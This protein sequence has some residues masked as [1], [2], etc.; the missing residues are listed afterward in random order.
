MIV[1]GEP[2]AKLRSEA[3]EL[4]NL[5]ASLGERAEI[6]VPKKILDNLRNFVKLCFE[7]PVDPA[8]Q[9]A[10]INRYILEFKEDIPGYLDVALMLYPHEDSKAFQY[11][12]KR[13]EFKKR[14]TSFIDTESLDEQSKKYA[15]NILD[16]PDFSIGTP[17]V[18]KSHIDFMSEIQIGDSIRNLRKF[19]DV[20][21]IVEHIE[22]GHWNFLMDT[23]EQMIV[24]SSHYTTKPEKDDFLHRT[25]WAVNFKGLNGL[26]RTVV[27]G[28]AETAYNLIAGEVFNKNCVKKIEHPVTE[29]H[30]NDLYNKM[31]EDNTS[32][33]VVKVDNARKNYFSGTKKWFP[34]LTRLVIV[35]DSPES[36]RTNTSLVFSFH[37]G[38]INTLNK[39]HTKKL[40]APANTQLNIRLILESV[41]R[42]KIVRFRDEINKK[43]KKFD[44][45]LKE[46]KVKQ[47]GEEDNFGF[48]LGLYK[49]DGFTRQ[50]LKDKYSLEK[51][52]DF[53]FFLENLYDDDTRERQNIELIKEFEAGI[54]KYF[55]SGIEQV[56]TA[57]IVEGGGRNQI[58]TYGEYALEKNLR[59]IVTEAKQKCALILDIL[60]NNY[61]RTLNNH[62][63][64]NFGINLFLEKYQEYIKKSVNEA[65]NKGRFKNFLI[66]LGIYD[67]FESKSDT[68]KKIITEFIGNLG[69]LDKTSIA[70]D[71]QMI[72]RDLL[73]NKNIKPKPYILFNKDLSWEYKDLFPDDRFDNNPFD[74]EINNTSD[75]R[76]DYDRLLQEIKR[77]KSSLQLFDPSG[78]LWD[79]F[80]EN[81][82]ILI[83]DPANPTG[84]SDFNSE[85][86][87]RFLDFINNSQITLFLDEAYNDGVKSADDNNPKWR[88]ISRYV[89]NNIRKYPRIHMVSSVSTT[90]NLGATGNRLG[91]LVAT[92]AS[93]DVTDFAR[94][95]NAEEKGKGNSNSLYML[96]NTID[97]ARMAKKVKDSL[98]STL[99]KD[100]SRYKIKGFIV[101]CIKRFTDE[102]QKRRT[103]AQNGNS[104]VKRMAGFEGSPLHV[105]LLEELV[106]LDKLDVL[107]VP[108]DFKYRDEPFYTYYLKH[109]VGEL[110][111]FRVNKNFRNESNKRLKIAKETAGKLIN[112]HHVDNIGIIKSDGSYLFNLQIKKFSSYTDLQLF[113]KRLASDRGIA[114]LPYKNG[115]MRF[116]LG[117]F[118]EGN[119]QSYEV[120]RK[121][122]E[123]A[124]LVFLDY[125][126]Q[127]ST[128]RNEASNKIATEEILDDIFKAKSEKEFIDCI[129]NDYKIAKEL[130]HSKIPGIRLNDIRTL[131]HASPEKSGVSITSI[132]NSKNSV[133]EF[134]SEIGECSDIK[135]FIISRAF[136]KVYEDL[137]SQV[138]KNIPQLK[139]LDFNAV[140]SKYSKATLYKYIN[141]KKTFHPNHF[142]LDD[143]EEENIMR[144][145]LIEMENLLFSDS[146]MKI[147]AI[148][149][150]EG[151]PFDDRSRL[152][153]VNAIL[154]R[155]VEEI[156]LHFNLPFAQEAVEPSRKEIMTITGERFEAV[157]GIKINE[158]NLD[159][160]IHGF[161]SELRNDKTFSDINIS[162]KNL[163]HIITVIGKRI[164]GTKVSTEDRLLYLYLL[165]HDNSFAKIVIDK[166]RFFQS[167]IDSEPDNEARMITEN[168]IES[169]VSD[170]LSDII[171]YII[172]KKDIKVSEKSLHKVTR[173]VVLFYIDIINKTKGTDYYEKYTHTLIKIVE[174]RFRKQNSCTN[175]MVQHGFSLLRGE[176]I[177]DENTLKLYKDANIEWIARL[178]MKCG[179]I[180]SEQPV[181]IH[182]RIVT[183]AKK[184]EYPFL[185]VDQI[186]SKTKQFHSE[187]AK[188][189]PNYFI[190]QIDLKPESKF[191]TNRLADFIDNLDSEDYRCKIAKFGLIKELMVIQK[192]YLKYLT[193]Y[194][195]LAYYED[196]KKED[197]KGFIPDVIMFYG[198]PEKLISFPQIGYFD[199][200]G[201][202]DKKIK[203]IVTPLKKE[204]DYFGDIKKPRLQM[205]NEKIKEIG[206][207]PKHGSLFVVEEE[208]GTVFG[209]EVDGDSGGGKSETIAAMILKWMRQDLSGVRSIKVVAG[210]MFHTFKD[211][212]GNLYGFGTEVGDFSRVTDFDPDFIDYYK[213]LFETSADSNVTDLNS[214][215]TI[216]G[217]CDIGMPFKIDIMLAAANYSKDEAGITLV[218]NPENFLL[219]VDSH[220]E[221]KEKATSEDGPNFQRTLLRYQSDPEIVDVLA[222]HGNYL[223]DIFDWEQDKSDKEFY[224]SS[225]YKIIDR[226]DVEDVVNQIFREKTFAYNG[227]KYTIQSV[228]FDVIAN[229]FVATVLSENAD[230][231]EMKFRIS[232]KIFSTI[233]DSLASTPGGQPFI[234]ETRQK[235]QRKI[236]VDIMKGKNGGKIQCGV[237]S[238]E[239]GKKGKEITGPQK[240]AEDM[241]RMIQQVRF[242]NNEE[243]NKSKNFIK[244]ELNNKYGYL[245]EA[246]MNSNKIWRYNYFLYQLHQMKT[247][248]FVSVYDDNI[249]I[250]FSSLPVF[251]EVRK[252]K[253]FSPLLITPNINIELNA[254]S[255]TWEDLI[256]LPNYT[257]FY[258]E[259]YEDIIEING[260]ENNFYIAKGHDKEL[261]INNMIIQLLLKEGY[262]EVDDLY[263]GRIT[264]K[265]NRETIAAAKKAVERFYK[266]KNQE[267]IE[268]NKV[269]KEVKTKIQKAENKQKKDQ[270]DNKLDDK[271]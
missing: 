6:F 227:C 188:N 153:G 242:Q 158:L 258:E 87:I 222:K 111:K 36:K 152:E 268:D 60:P 180:S 114:V 97:I 30:Y 161:I 39:V 166:F 19:R 69:N 67:A 15:A 204:V 214:R 132:G 145:I 223:D 147:L 90:K 45:E 135:S 228:S 141:N 37:N 100:A 23:I 245:F 241:K 267:K 159:S 210:D 229:R 194:N 27:S 182:T 126:K 235:E 224:L 247:A 211:K 116:S 25:E 253:V 184:R 88:I 123:N 131:Y 10:E 175:E 230:E 110:N 71:V 209:V 14:L 256:S 52:R 225:S 179:V 208:D 221:R 9:Q 226:I 220:G 192:G 47:F 215:S 7:E 70:D 40:G 11:S 73:F 212:D 257:E 5:Y 172:R 151:K 189:D 133:L 136:T 82:T 130:T 18:T 206:G 33:F 81:L 173:K 8:K 56:H 85:K 264:E 261:V 203:T 17:P 266:E 219:Y 177:F 234:A 246:G 119:A 174:T 31:L 254:F 102:S 190:T 202:E 53:L 50:L 80:S 207:I 271:K 156:L 61:D 201:P 167:R 251:K 1:N 149:P 21:G 57:T 162:E 41:G 244:N 165:K 118:I 163:G 115:V 193:D 3:K 155:Y 98:E 95:R 160:Y 48:N 140:A 232:R 170:E 117:G 186:A 198:A 2:K 64:K 168:V 260:K 99:P 108:D 236:L 200:D 171:D 35:D 84:Y 109:I 86:L 157:T 137:L 76:I 239:I 187:K 213:Y 196:I 176:D 231:D 34:M 120:F 142:V 93:K 259:F 191:F 218:D 83:N 248:E 16:M 104:R 265:V 150:S 148:N 12:S 233:F 122:F 143:P 129:L 13:L 216:S 197:L 144:E 195:R 181:Q 29:K 128:A 72:V 127:F 178:M 78:N 79:R 62:F 107:N 269:I 255:E 22:E 89:M 66:D 75:G 205:I 238:T 263:K 237:L 105:F 103:A 125:W 32:I 54:K 44:S 199:I 20:I 51:F 77:I 250:D 169:L 63:H 249:K 262:I 252:S 112:E 154:K 59:E 164:L 134:N 94:S 55:Y 4:I 46:L 243:I 146:K 49:Y 113:S 91:V 42:D 65:D 24:Q 101:N 43:L 68:E 185:G 58:R 28:N 183:D 121:D 217:L 92:P 106:A 96:N 270:A 74:L 26:I 139:N 240:A 138:Y 38:I 124:M